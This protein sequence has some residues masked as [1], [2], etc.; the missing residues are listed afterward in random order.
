MAHICTG[1]N[2]LPAVS[3]HPL[4]FLVYPNKQTLKEKELF[5]LVWPAD[6]LTPC[7]HRPPPDF[8]PLSRGWLGY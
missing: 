3:M 7:N 4:I 1:G 5:F 6:T 8:W 2:H